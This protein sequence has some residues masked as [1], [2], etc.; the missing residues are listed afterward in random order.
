MVDLRN[1]LIRLAYQNPHLRSH[2]L[3]LLKEASGSW[4]TLS[5]NA[6]KLHLDAVWAMYENT[7][8]QIGMHLPNPQ[9]LLKYDEWDLYIES[10]VPLAFSLGEK[11]RYGIKG[12]LC[13]SYPK[14]KSALTPY[15]QRK[16]KSEGYYGE[17]SNKLKDLFVSIDTPVVCGAFVT[18]VL[19]KTVEVLEDGISYTRSLSNIGKVTKV[20]FGR[21]RGIPVTTYQSPQCPL[22]E[23]I[24][25]VASTDIYDENSWMDAQNHVACLIKP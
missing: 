21:P 8:A 7:Y 23:S 2:L 20:L 19:G 9:G 25:V 15:F 10:G 6:R 3:P 1:N 11:T 5:G 13:G 12:S 17:A 14:G 24:R 18:Q 22:V 16:Y 4:V